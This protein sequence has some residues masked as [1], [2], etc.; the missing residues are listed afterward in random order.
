MCCVVCF[1]FDKADIRVPTVLQPACS[2]L[3]VG[4]VKKR[5]KG[6]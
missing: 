3:S 5:V 4:G 1:V 2:D 6:E